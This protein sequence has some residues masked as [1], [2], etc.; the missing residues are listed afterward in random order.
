MHN[1]SAPAFDELAGWEFDGVNTSWI[2]GLGGVR[3]SQVEEARAAG[4]LIAEDGL[5]VEI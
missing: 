2:A 5:T 3:M 1:G 4:L